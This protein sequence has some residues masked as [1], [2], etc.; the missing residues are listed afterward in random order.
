M[1]IPD[2]VRR[3]IVRSFGDP[4]LA[5]KVYDELGTD[6]GIE[7]LLKCL[8]DREVNKVAFAGVAHVIDF[9]NYGAIAD[10]QLYGRNRPENPEDVYPLSI[11]LSDG[12]DLPSE[13]GRACLEETMLFGKEAMLYLSQEQPRL[14]KW[15]DRFAL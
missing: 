14:L 12:K 5:L 11:I 2:K 3:R 9:P 10:L 6:A 1:P 7:A 13:F 4:S 8:Q 15:L